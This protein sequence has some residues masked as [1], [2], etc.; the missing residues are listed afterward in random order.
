MRL[1]QLEYFIKVV[2]CG[3]ITKAA[4][5]LYLSQPS[6]TKAISGLEAEY[7]LKLFSR[8]ARGLN[9]TPEGR[10][11]LEYAKGVTDSTHALENTFGK[12]NNL[13]IQR[14]AVA[15]QQFDFI[16]DIL[17]MLY[18]ENREKLLQIDLK[19]ND[20][21]EIVEMVAECRADIGILAISEKDSRSFRSE[22]KN[23]NLEMYPLDSS[24]VY[25]SMGKKSCLYNE[26]AVD[27]GEAEK[28]LHLS[29]DT[30]QGMRRELRCRTDRGDGINHEH[31]IF[32]NTVGVCRRFLDETEALLLTPK[33]VLGFFEGTSIR[34]VPLMVDGKHYPLVN[35]LVWIKRA[36]EMFR[37]LEKRF[38][39]LL[40]DRFRPKPYA[41]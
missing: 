7:D 25:V 29:L 13:F 14:L 40:E 3:S 26:E 37:P 22:L 32:C 9:L 2:E 19:E 11:F 5:E 23:R 27:V 28:Y 24:S 15:S 36:N 10:D 1:N 34:S 41:S 39:E 16:Y 33:W 12:K 38:M 17:L 18:K 21:G 31:M 6:L 8:T 20:R 4:Q 30:D 35:R